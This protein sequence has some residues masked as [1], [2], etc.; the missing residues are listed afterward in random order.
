MTTVAA[1]WIK[2]NIQALL[3]QA[4]VIH[5]CSINVQTFNNVKYGASQDIQQFCSVP[6][7]QLASHAF[8]KPLFTKHSHTVDFFGMKATNN[9]FKC[10]VTLLPSGLE[11]QLTGILYQRCS[12]IYYK[13]RDSQFQRL[14]IITYHYS[15]HEK[16]HSSNICHP[17]F[18]QSQ[19]LS[20]NNC[21]I[22][23]AA[24]TDLI[25]PLKMRKVLRYIKL[26]TQNVVQ[27]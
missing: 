4:H 27:I 14:I 21:K 20:V 24:Q 13:L 3:M 6:L 19:W 9:C 7:A 17:K 25:W 8:F 10:S 15:K 11:K 2:L 12:K 5:T 1:D 26:L 18:V 22:I 16:V 23:K